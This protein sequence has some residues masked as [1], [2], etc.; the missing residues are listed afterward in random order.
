MK[1]EP[2]Y[3]LLS[4]FQLF[5]DLSEPELRA[6]VQQSSREN[7]RAGDR[8]ISEGDEGHSMYVVLQGTARVTFQETLLT[9]LAPGDFF[10]EISLVD[11]G[12]RSADV[13]A[14]TGM[15]V[16]VIT[17]MTLGVLAGVQPDAA[18]HILAA[19]GKALVAKL[20]ADNARFREVLL[21]DRKKG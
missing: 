3:S 12:P 15:E 14:E 10:G 7:F 20:R 21:L 6:L 9:R 13:T 19:I 1:N 2:D 16:L 11:D 4:Q 8:I 17:R 5:A 18:I